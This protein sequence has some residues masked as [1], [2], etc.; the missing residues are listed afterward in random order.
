MTGNSWLLS[1]RSIN[2]LIVGATAWLCSSGALSILL[3][4]TIKRLL[5][6]VLERPGSA[7]TIGSAYSRYCAGWVLSETEAPLHALAA[8]SD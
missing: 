3:T 4:T 5:V 8:L 7:Y 1:R 2:A 6:S